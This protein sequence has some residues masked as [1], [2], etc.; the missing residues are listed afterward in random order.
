MAGEGNQ[1]GK[2]NQ[3][4]ERVFYSWGC[5]VAS[6]PW[7]VI[8]AT[9]LITGLG[10]LGLLGFSAETNAWKMLLPEGSRYWKNQEWKNGHFV[11]DTRQT[12]FF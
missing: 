2:V 8:A 10:S 5:T 9:L 11:E 1:N 6:N 3:F 12:S 4:F 7:T